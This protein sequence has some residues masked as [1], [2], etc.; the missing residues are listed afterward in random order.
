[1]SL[2]RTLLRPRLPSKGRPFASS[3]PIRAQSTHAPFTYRLGASS[4]G[5]S[6]PVAPP[7]DNN[8]FPQSL[9]DRDDPYFNSMDKFSGEDAF[10]MAKIARSDRHV[11]FGLADG[12]GGWRDSGIDPGRF[13][14]GLCRYMAQKT[15]R[16]DA[17]ADLK[18]RNLL[19]FGYEKVM[20]DRSVQ[21]GGCTACIGAI[22]PSGALEVAN[23]G[24]SGFLILAPGK[25]SF[26][27][28]AQTHAFNTPYQLSKLTPRMQAQ[29]RIFG[30]TGQISE[31]PAQSDVTTHSLHHGE[32]VIFATDGVL[33]NLSGM[34][35]LNIVQP[36]MEKRG[37][38]SAAEGVESKGAIIKADKL[39]DPKESG[40]LSNLPSELAYSIMR[41]AKIAGIDTRRDGPFAKEVHK[42][43]PNEEYHGG[44]PD[45][46]AVIVALAVQDGALKAKL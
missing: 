40:N 28:P 5:K 33:D 22:E 14:H 8:V 10:F 29:N 24:D 46:I 2:R 19:Q 32:L 42:H 34:D 43:F 21:A 3:S 45:D 37:Y 31:T 41:N 20:S 25:V 11:V 15:H 7:S 36:I 26:M 44:K 13:S 30:N 35:I 39:R 4:S 6:S 16:P 1:M 12:V 9:L 17:E 18:P 27:S 38:W 23:L